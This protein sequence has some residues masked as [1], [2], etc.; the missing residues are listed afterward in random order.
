[1]TFN[2]HKLTYARLVKVTKKLCDALENKSYSELDQI[3]KEHKKILKKLNEIGITKNKEL[4]DSLKSVNA[5]IDH[6]M[7]KINTRYNDVREKI[8]IIM[9][10]KKQIAAYGKK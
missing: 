2:S 6:A 8:L 10:R 7:L 1:M 5:Y 3:A 9:K 4:L